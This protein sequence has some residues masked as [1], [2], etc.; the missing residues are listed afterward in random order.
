MLVDTKQRKKA[1][2]GFRNSSGK[3]KTLSILINVINKG[4]KALDSL[5]LDLGRNK[6]GLH[7]V[8]HMAVAG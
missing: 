2:A 8:Y 6:H 5:M 1:M 7:Q 3:E 4:K